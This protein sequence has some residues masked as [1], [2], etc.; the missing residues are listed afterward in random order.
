MRIKEISAYQAYAQDNAKAV[1]G[2]VA[3][4]ADEEY[5]GKDA[6]CT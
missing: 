6:E 2:F 4:R 1:A 3:S 5:A